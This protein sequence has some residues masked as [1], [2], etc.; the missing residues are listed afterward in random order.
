[1][2]KTKVNIPERFKDHPIFNEQ[3]LGTNFGFMAKRGWYLREE[4]K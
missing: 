2:D 4:A 1:M 3:I